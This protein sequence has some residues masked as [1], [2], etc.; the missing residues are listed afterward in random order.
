MYQS[1]CENIL[2]SVNEAGIATIT[3]NRSEVL[4]TLTWEME[5]ELRKL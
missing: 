2:F 1:Q 4:N 3:L 5:M